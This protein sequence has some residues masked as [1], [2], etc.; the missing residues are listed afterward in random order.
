MKQLF[1]K[2]TQYTVHSTKTYLSLFT[3]FYSAFAISQEQPKD[4]TKV[5][6][7]ND[8]PVTIMMDSKQKQ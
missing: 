6:L 1:A 2:S 5:T 7:L 4:S 3:L 8:G